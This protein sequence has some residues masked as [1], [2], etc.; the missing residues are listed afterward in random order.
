M[1]IDF[2]LRPDEGLP[3]SAY[4]RLGE[5]GPVVWSEPLDGW[6][7]CSFEAVRTVLGDVSRFTM[8]GT[9]VAGPGALEPCATLIWP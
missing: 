8:A 2:E 7:A 6:L 4:R 1:Q 9:P 3:L 5:E